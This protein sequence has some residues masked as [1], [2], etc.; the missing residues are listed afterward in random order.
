MQP[1][2]HWFRLRKSWRCQSKLAKAHP[3]PVES[4]WDV[5]YARIIGF[6]YLPSG[7]TI[8]PPLRIGVFRFEAGVLL[9]ELLKEG[10]RPTVKLRHLLD[11]K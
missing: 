11:G 5:A 9:A 1:I 7:S 3:Q 4:W 2:E 8:A 10:Q 6:Q